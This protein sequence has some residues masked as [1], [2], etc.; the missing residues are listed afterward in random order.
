MKTRFSPRLAALL[1][2]IA[3]AALTS[4]TASAEQAPQWEWEEVSRIVAV[5]DIHGA[6]HPLLITLEGIG[7]IGEDLS[8]RG[9]E[10]HLVFV[11]DLID[12]G[13]E[14]REVL[15]LA[16]RLQAEAQA[17][18]GRVHVLLGNHDVMNIARDLRYVTEPSFAAF[19]DIEL[20]EDRS[21][22]RKRYLYNARQAGL[23]ARAF[24]KEFPPGYFGRLRAFT[25]EGE[26]GAW[27]LEQP[28]AIKLNGYLF[29]HGGLTP[30]VAQLGL[31]AIN[32]NVQRDLREYLRQASVLDGVVGGL[33]DYVELYTLAEARAASSTK[34]K[35]SE[36]GT[37][38][39]RLLE[40]RDALPF[41]PGGPFWYRGASLEN[42]RIE[43]AM[44]S[45]TLEH[46]DAKAMVIG[47]TPTRPGVITSRFNESVY[48]IDV[49]AVYRAKSSA[50]VIDSAGVTVFDPLTLARNAPLQEPGMGEG[51]ATGHEELPA[52][53]LE[54]FLSR[55]KIEKVEE[56]HR[57]GRR[58][59]I[60]ELK[61]KGLHL[62]AIFGSADEAVPPGTAPESFNP[63]RYQHEIAAYRLDRMLDFGFVPVTA[64]RK[65]A[66]ESGAIQV[67][68]EEAVDLP[69]IETHG[70]FDMLRGLESHIRE[71]MILFALI[72]SRE[73]VDAGKMLLPRQRRVM[74]SD[75]TRGFPL[76][77]EVEDLLVPQRDEIKLGSCRPMDPRQELALRALTRK[78]LLAELGDYLFEEQIDALL[79]RRDRILELCGSAE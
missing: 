6:Y 25:A 13:D 51:W 22:G 68:L 52:S 66:K 63:R 74:I 30:D 29:V 64:P 1:C 34:K 58:F 72:G 41:A 8:W 59:L 10:T 78:G 43:R 37:A 32:A 57:V 18:G 79:G 4:A 75:S 35:A 56:V 28:T 44:V 3:A 48:R 69:Y 12:R 24:D 16:R 46:L 47:H 73:R 71:V 31:D 21:A 27:L 36:V 60:V 65:V 19:A 39:R 17:A 15:D 53:V 45:A 54:R 20:A 42:E 70:R 67:F 14:D 49:G 5:G 9:G 2:L 33:P 26:Y 7:L 61:E 76:T 23:E 11:G 55:A 40:L 77:T 62:R 38:A 50:L